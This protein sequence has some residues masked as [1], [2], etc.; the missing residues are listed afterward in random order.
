MNNLKYYLLLVVSS[1]LI[2]CSNDSTKKA[3]LL[4]SIQ[5]TTLPHTSL[6][7]NDMTSFKSVSSNWAIVGNANA[8]PSNKGVFLNETGTGILMNSPTSNANDNIFTAFDH[9]DLEIELDVMMP[10]GSNSGIYFQGRYEV[11]LFDSWNVAN[12]QYSDM[13]GIY[14]QWDD[15]KSK[16]HEGYAPAINA[17]KA[18]GLWQHYKIKFQAAR[19]DPSGKKIKNAVFQEVWLNG[20]LLHENQEVSGPT[21]SSAF[22]DE[23]SLG[24]LMFQGD[25]GAVAF[26]NIKYKLYDNKTVA[27]S[28]MQLTEYSEY[29]AVTRNIPDYSSLTV[30]REFKTDTISS[31]MASGQ[32]PQ[33]L[34]VYSGTMNFPNS[35][36]YIFDMA[37]DGGGMLL[38]VDSDT[39]IAMDSDF[40]LNNPRTSLSSFNAG[41]HPF[42]LIYNK[43][44]PFRSGFALFV[45]GPGVAK[46]Q[47]HASSSIDPSRLIGNGPKVHIEVADEAVL[48]RG[49]LMHKGVKRT[50]VISVGTPQDIHYSYDL[51]NGSL[52]QFWGGSFLDATGMWVG[53]GPEQLGSPIGDPLVSFGGPDF[54]YLKNRRAAWPDSIPTNS[55]YKQLGYE[56]DTQGNPTFSI[57]IDGAVITNQLLPSIGSRSLNRVITTNSEE[58]IW[59]K[60]GEGDIIESLSD[61]RYIMVDKAYFI[62]LESSELYKPLI[63]E[64]NGKAELLVKIP[65]G[66]Q[67]FAYTL[68][69]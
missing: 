59:H 62:Q 36:D 20:Y 42:T 67:E 3:A 30:E 13:G 25:H 21:Q 49:F 40:Y 19:F 8:D 32:N 60:L 9:G 50:H 64:S 10:N 56:L 18:P 6:A 37:V 26:R 66:T 23:Q 16:G 63:R 24:P 15:A 14:Q 29:E 47:L 43:H 27:F 51:A 61:G 17:S 12:P 39:I 31:K 52:L 55:T 4:E 11:Q 54:A 35:G 33:K 7:L 1:F 45:E 68:I 57:E 2:A 22:Q 41:G 44:R 58:E 38:I 53:R 34:L 5:P 28:N 46:H 65:A 48:Q 69:W